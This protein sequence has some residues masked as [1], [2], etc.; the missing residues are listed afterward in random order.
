LR[1]VSG[2]A[3]FLRFYRKNLGGWMLRIC[4]MRRGRQSKAGMLV[5]YVYRCGGEV[6]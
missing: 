6:M 4:G 2:D 5:E 3:L 1:E